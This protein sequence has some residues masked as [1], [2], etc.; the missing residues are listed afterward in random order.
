MRAAGVL[1]GVSAQADPGIRE[2]NFGHRDA[3]RLHAIFAD[4]NLAAGVRPD[5]LHLLTNQTATC[6][7]VRAALKDAANAVNAGHADIL[8]L[9]FSCHGTQ[10]GRLVLHDTDIDRV[11]DTTIGLHELAEAVAGIPEAQV[12]IT[13]DACFSGT[14]LGQPGSLNRD[15]FDRFMQPLRGEGRFVVWAAGPDEEA[16][17]SSVLAHGYLS[18][19]L[20]DALETFRATGKR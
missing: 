11:N 14:V 7:A 18:H 1:V 6:E 16:Y 8:I 10:S 5:L 20:A 4:A 2:L 15:A 9:H 3:E 17:E 12:V 19:A 13:L